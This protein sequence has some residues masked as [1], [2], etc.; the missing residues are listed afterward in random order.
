MA[1]RDEIEQDL[2]NALKEKNT[3]RVSLLRMLLSAINYKEIDKKNPLSEDE[4]HS[5]VK[6]MIKQH[7]ESIES[8]RKGQR[9]DLAEKEEKEL[10]ILKEFVPA[11]LAESEIQAEMEA[12]I[13]ALEAKDQKDMGKVMKFLMD[14]LASRVD[15]KVLSEMVRKRLSS[16]RPS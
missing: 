14:K 6:T 7:T 2:K 1:Y 9:T 4:F 11:Q 3:T 15:G 10:A 12:A 5:V 16:P 13:T 8:F